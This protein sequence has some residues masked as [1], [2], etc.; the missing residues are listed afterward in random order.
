MTIPFTLARNQ[1]SEGELISMKQIA[2]ICG[3]SYQY[4]RELNIGA[5]NSRPEFPKPDT[6]IGKSKRPLWHKEKILKW[7]SQRLDRA[8]RVR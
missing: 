1:F 4:V 8:R 6:V 3:F 5:E 7:D 2:E